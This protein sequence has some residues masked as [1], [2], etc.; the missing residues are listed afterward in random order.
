[1]AVQFKTTRIEFDQTKDKLQDEPFSVNFSSHVLRAE[2]VLN[3]FSIKF[4]EGDHPMHHLQIN[5]K[6][7]ETTIRD[8]NVSGRVQF[9]LRDNSGYY[10]D[11]FGGWVDVTVIAETE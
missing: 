5:V 9:G 11:R 2:G 1:M 8:K 6:D 7:S 3:G 10:D 4:A